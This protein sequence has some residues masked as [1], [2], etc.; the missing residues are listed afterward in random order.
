MK[1]HLAD[2]ANFQ[3]LLNTHKYTDAWSLLKTHEYTLSP[4]EFLKN[5]HLVQKYGGRLKHITFGPSQEGLLPLV[6][7][8]A[9]ASMPPPKDKGFLWWKEKQHN[10][11][12]NLWKMQSLH[13]RNK[14]TTSFQ[15]THKQ[16]MHELRNKFPDWHH[17]FTHFHDA[18]IEKK[19]YP[20][21][22][23]KDYSYH[24][25]PF[26]IHAHGEQLRHVFDKAIRNDPYKFK[27]HFHQPR[28]YR[29]ILHTLGSDGSKNWAYHYD[30][31]NDLSRQHFHN[32]IDT[33]LDKYANFKFAHKSVE[34]RMA[35]NLARLYQASRERSNKA[36]RERAAYR[37]KKGIKLQP[38]K[39]PKPKTT[40]KKKS[41]KK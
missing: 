20:N 3:K 31:M 1:H 28:D 34:Q 29:N 7:G 36:S 35:E 21:V 25:D 27:H 17:E 40:K 23:A 15:E 33:T 32:V 16:F 24:N 10:A 37:K 38:A 26:E 13:P 22:L 5:D 30:K 19:P 6:K 14:D 41:K 12:I 11:N 9:L 4:H 18:V 39:A 2:P 8:S